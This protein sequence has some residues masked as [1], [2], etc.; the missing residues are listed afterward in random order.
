MAVS[1]RISMMMCAEQDQ[2]GGFDSLYNGAAVC[3]YATAAD[4]GCC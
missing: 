4:R 3:I 2:I 1:D